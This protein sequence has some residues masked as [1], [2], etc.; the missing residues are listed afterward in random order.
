MDDHFIPQQKH[1]VKKKVSQSFNNDSQLQ[2]HYT[3]GGLGR[4]RLVGANADTAWDFLVTSFFTQPSGGASGRQVG[5]YG[6]LRG[7]K[8]PSGRQVVVDTHDNDT[9]NKFKR[10]IYHWV[11]VNYS[12]GS[13]TKAE[14]RDMW[15]EYIDYVARG[16]DPALGPLKKPPKGYRDLCQAYMI[17]VTEGYYRSR[18]LEEE[19]VGVNNLTPDEEAL[20]DKNDEDLV[21]ARKWGMLSGSAHRGVYHGFSRVKVKAAPYDMK[22][23]GTWGVVASKRDAPIVE[24]QLV[25]PR[26]VDD[27]FNVNASAKFN[28]NA[29]RAKALEPYRA[30]SKQLAIS[31]ELATF[32]DGS[33]EKNVDGWYNVFIAIDCA[34][35]RTWVET[36]RGK[37]SWS[38]LGRI[39]NT[40]DMPQHLFCNEYRA[41]F[42][43]PKMLERWPNDIM[44]MLYDNDLATA[45][46]SLCRDEEMESYGKKYPSLLKLMEVELP[47]GEPRD[48]YQTFG[49]GT[50]V[51]IIDYIIGGFMVISPW[52][53]L[54]CQDILSQTNWCGHFGKFCEIVHHEVNSARFAEEDE[55]PD[56]RYSSSHE[57]AWQM[58]WLFCFTHMIAENLMREGDDA[59]IVQMQGLVEDMRMFA[60]NRVTNE[61]RFLRLMNGPQILTS[62]ATVLHNSVGLSL[63]RRGTLLCAQRDRGSRFVL[64]VQMLLKR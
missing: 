10:S 8:L 53:I 32:G 14:M 33:R 41:G 38:D 45:F 1:A 48:M 29:L 51:S 56:M 37:F 42:I 31:K 20:M 12:G 24:L 50:D 46:A 54:C 26:W 21:E 23:P 15:R 34:Y 60:Y 17:M 13:I 64:Y 47:G 28:A 11:T 44:N 63:P 49:E 18:F 4:R 59:A 36:R 19:L 52:D 55:D 2:P 5:V 6:G 39:P 62:G 30:G 58:P 25:G 27:D 61:T 16:G 43:L 22:D 35:Q 57:K 40:P 9:I 7:L 3:L